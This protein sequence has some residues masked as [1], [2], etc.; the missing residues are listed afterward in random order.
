MK[1]NP[2]NGA[3]IAKTTSDRS[4]LS[5]STKYHKKSEVDKKNFPE[6]KP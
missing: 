3:M 1:A 6:R 4:S 2:A 5:S